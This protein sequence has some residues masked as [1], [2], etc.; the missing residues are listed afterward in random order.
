MDQ[1]NQFDQ[2]DQF[3]Q[4]SQPPTL[5]GTLLPSSHGPDASIALAPP[6]LATYLTKE[7]LFEAI[8]TWSKP[9]GYAFM[10]IRSRRISDTRQKV[11]YGCNRSNPLPNTQ[12]ERIRRTQTRG[13]ECLFQVV[14]FETLSLGW[15]VRYRTETKFNT[16]NHLPSPSPAAHPSHR[17]LP[18]IAQ[19]TAQDLFQQVKQRI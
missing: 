1:F 17:R 14:A 12:I 4:S 5:S 3:D 16:H 10:V 9:W 13:L 15:E 8:Q 19:N 11:Y 2:V 7:A 18:T 6:P